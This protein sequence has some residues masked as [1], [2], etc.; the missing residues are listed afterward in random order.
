[1]IV[2]ISCVL[3]KC[4]LTMKKLGNLCLSLGRSSLIHNIVM[5]HKKYSLKE[6]LKINIVNI[7][8][9]ILIIKSAWA[10]T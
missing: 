7:V 8:K 1:M 6:H 5:T 4:M 3:K 10:S 2:L 9:F